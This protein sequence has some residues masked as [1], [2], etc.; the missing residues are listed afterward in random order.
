MAIGAQTPAEPKLVR[1]SVPLEA[2]NAEALIGELASILVSA[3]E[4]AARGGERQQARA[5]ETNAAEPSS[6]P[7]PEFIYRVLVEQIPAVVCIAYLDEGKSQAYISPQIEATLGFSREEW[8]DDA[9]LWSQQ[10]HPDDKSRWNRE[11]AS[12]FAG[13]KPLKSAYRVLARDG[14][15]VWFQCEAKMVRRP[16]GQPW[17]ILGVGFD[18]SELKEAEQALAERTESLRRLSTTLLELQDQERRRIAR[19]LHDGIGQCLVALKLNFEMLA[20]AQPKEQGELWAESRRLLEQCLLDTRN[21][22][23]L[24]HPPLLDEVGLLLAIKAYVEGFSKRTGIEARLHLPDLLPA[25]SK[26]FELVIFRVLQES[27]TNVVRHSGSKTVDIRLDCHGTA[28]SLDVTDSGHGMPAQVLDRLSRNRGGV[29]LAGMRERMA[30]LGGS[31]EINSDAGGTQV[32]AVLPVQGGETA[33]LDRAGE[34]DRA[35]QSKA[36]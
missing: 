26:G 11:V 6:R 5:T 17:F 27:L 28:I 31:F 14:R 13:G 33:S 24:L 16:D 35:E 25:V 12:M 22:S 15:I 30:E 18:I 36:A 20:G 8:I 32:R 19:E 23:Y 3:H 34:E 1:G 4:R 29:G 21:L 9:G 10:L 2:G 7:A